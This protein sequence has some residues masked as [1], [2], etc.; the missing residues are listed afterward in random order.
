MI[1]QS[2]FFEEVKAGQFMKFCN[3]KKI[4][5]MLLKFAESLRS[6]RCKSVEILLNRVDLAKSFPLDPS[7]QRVFTICLQESASI[8]PRTRDSQSR[9]GRWVRVSTPSWR[10]NNGPKKHN[11]F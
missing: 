7:F 5:A 4:D 2:R 10:V 3:N 1:Q 6:K 8:Q 9:A 11:A